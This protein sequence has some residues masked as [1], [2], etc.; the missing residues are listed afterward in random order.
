MTAHKSNTHTRDG[1]PTH[2]DNSDV[3]SCDWVRKFVGYIGL[4]YIVG[5][6]NL[7]KVKHHQY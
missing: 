3:A 7:Y 5:I 1:S 2:W 4:R 6:E